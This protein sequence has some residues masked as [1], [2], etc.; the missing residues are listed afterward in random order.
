[1]GQV[2]ANSASKTEYL[3]GKK[4]YLN[5]YFTQYTKIYLRCTINLN[6]NTKITQ[7]L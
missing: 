7:Y 2:A 5:P 4:M 1:M 3:Q 6:V